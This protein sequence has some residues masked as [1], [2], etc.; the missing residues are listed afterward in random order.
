MKKIFLVASGFSL[1]FLF[2]FLLS[3]SLDS[4]FLGQIE[5][6]VFRSNWREQS[7]LSLPPRPKDPSSP[8]PVSFAPKKSSPAPSS[9]KST[10]PFLLPA[11]KNTKKQTPEALSFYSS[12]PLTEASAYVSLPVPEATSE[13]SQADLPSPALDQIPESA[14][15]PIPLTSFFTELFRN[16]L[17]SDLT[18]EAPPDEMPSS[19]KTTMVTSDT[20]SSLTQEQKTILQRTQTEIQTFRDTIQEIKQNPSLLSS[21]QENT[22]LQQQNTITL[23]VQSLENQNLDS[24]SFSDVK[25][26][27]AQAEAEFSSLLS[28]A[29]AVSSFSSAPIIQKNIPK[30]KKIFKASNSFLQPKII[31][32]K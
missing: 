32:D 24:A 3:F 29:Q 6:S 9:P 25:G 18:V 10:E 28:S 30:E 11:F 27:W 7:N 1:G 16:K 23:D 21:D 20:S 4:H 5:T 31:Q 26:A 17:S 14:P 8:S 13:P 15:V 2:V 19:D 12:E 22:L